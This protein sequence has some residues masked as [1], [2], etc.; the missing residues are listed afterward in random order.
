[1]KILVSDKVSNEGVKILQQ[2][3]E[4]DVRHGL[5]PEELI[6][7][8]PQYDALV[9][10][11]E[12]KVRR[13]VIEAATNLKVIGRAGVGVDNIDIQA[14]TEKGIMVINAPDGNTI[15]AAELTMAMM[16]A[17]ARNVPQAHRSM[18]EGKW[19]RSKFM[20]AEMQGKTL[21]IIGLGRIGTGV[22][23]R[24]LAFDMKV[25]AFD[26]FIT[27]EKA[28]DLGIELA[29]LD[30]IYAQSDFITLHTP[31]TPETKH[32][33]ND[34]AFAKMKKG[35]RIV[36]CARGGLIDEKALFKAIQ[37]GIVAGAAID[38][39]EKEPV[40]LENP[41]L[42]LD[43]VIVTPH[44]GASTK[45]AQVGV[46]VDVAAGVLAALNGEPVSTAV[47]MPPVPQ[48]VMQFIKPYFQ[49]VE[50]MG[51]LAAHLSDGRIQTIEVEYK[52]EIGE[53]DSKMLTIATLKGVLN[54]ILQESVNY[55]NAPSIAKSRGIK[56]REVKSEE[57]ENFANL[58]SVRIRTDKGERRVAGTLFGQEVRIVM[59]D[60]Y[61]VD[62]AP[63]GWLLIVP[64]NDHPGIIGSVGCVLGEQ[65]INI[66]GMQVVMTEQAGRSIMF[67]EVESDV[68]NETLSKIKTLNGI[69]GAKLVNFDG[70]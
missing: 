38:V 67:L 26:P 66:K 57:M 63:K 6:E 59:I 60:G 58:I 2:T 27:E 7:A 16:L 25:M 30:R 49:L 34:D 11:S 54:P 39:F 18:K 44:L 31:L 32:I 52:G 37:E 56:V 51:T 53:I 55:I 40:T 28:L 45:E 14:A 47:N 10:R 17:L 12:T 48:S 23:K 61:R 13:A 36:Q 5:S 8:I 46:A 24:A 33:L 29:E 20:G 50:K 70:Q 41:L 64:H 42:T 62:V 15:A 21:G 65:N 68:S 1:M 3:H 69:F 9:V 19:E 43:N 22:V 35:I 4:V